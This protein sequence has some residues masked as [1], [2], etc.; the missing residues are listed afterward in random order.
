MILLALIP[1]IASLDAV[2]DSPAVRGA[3]VSAYICTLDGTRLY[4]RNEDLRLLPASNEK[5]VTGAF[6]LDAL[7]PD[8]RPQTRFWVRPDRVLVDSPGDPGMTY[9]QLLT[10]KTLL[11]LDGKKPVWVHQAYRPGNPSSWE[12]D[13]LPNRYAAPVT[14]FTVNRGGVEVWA[15]KGRLSLE[16]A[17]LGISLTRVAI[18][19]P[20]QVSYDLSSGQ[21]KVTG[22]LPDKRTKIDA[23][24]VREPDRQAAK[25]LGTD[26][27]NLD[28]APSDPPTY[29]WTGSPLRDLL[30]ECLTISDNVMAENLLLM[31]TDRKSPLTDDPYSVA[32]A[33]IR[34]FLV[35]KVGIAP[36]AMRPY[37][38]SGLSRHNM[39]TTRGLAQILVWAN[40]QPTA[41]VW[42]DSL[43]VPGGGTLVGRL[44]KS[45]FQG[46]TGTLEGVAALTGYLRL[47]DGKPVVISFIV[48]DGLADNRTLRDVADSFVRAAEVLKT[49]D[50]TGSKPVASLRFR[51]LGRPEG[52]LGN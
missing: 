6:A 31:A 4:G 5:L 39:V 16:P 38:G 10:I 28:Q 49:T 37:D 42:K 21:A 47:A 29:V 46:K 36:E 20:P 25:I 34:R 8:Y 52:L 2:L 35:S 14:A 45:T 33:A 27:F 17:P 24:A 12:W 51:G 43:D 19:G 30:K 44:D 41:S 40:A 9:D 13:D 1:Q 15:E 50:F 11:K 18:S 7:G 22:D 3:E 23:L 48:N 32:R 26:L